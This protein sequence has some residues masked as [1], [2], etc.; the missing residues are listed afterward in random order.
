[1]EAL[2]KIF[3]SNHRVKVM[4][5]FLFNNTLPFDIDDIA[6]RTKVRKP[7]LRKELAMLT[8]IGFIKKKVFF[9][10]VEKKSRKKNAK[11]E[12]R[13]VKKQ[14]WILNAQ[15]KLIKPLQSLLLDSELIQEK[16][17]IKK[18]KKAGAIK[19][20]VLSGL[21]IRDDNRVI[22]I[23]VVGNNIKRDVLNREMGII[24]SEIGRELSYA[25]F[26]ETEFQYRMS[27]YDKLV[28]DILENDH[29]LLINKISG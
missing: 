10:K 29:R 13:S 26:D 27:M 14:G 21:F 1:M 24:E 8:K 28:R 6:S 15:F 18:V 3:G 16:D 19:L 20:L 7:D 9:A 22:D 11:P 25:F 5:L 17:M 2:G 4:R 12:F 23:L